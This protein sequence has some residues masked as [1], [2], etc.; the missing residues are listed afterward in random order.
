MGAM[1]DYFDNALPTEQS[2]DLGFSVVSQKVDL[3]VHFAA[4]VISG[5][6]EITIQ[7]EVKDLKTIR[8]NCRQARILSVNVEGSKANHTYTDPY[9]K[10]TL[11]GKR[12]VHQHET[13]RNRIDGATKL[14]P[15]PELAVTIPSR[16]TIRELNSDSSV[17]PFRDALKRQESDAAGRAETPTTSH[18]QESTLRYAPLR[19]VIEFEVRKFRDG[20]H[21]VG[22][23]EQ[24]SRYPHLYTRNTLSPG[25][26]SSVFPC[27]DD[28]STRCMWEISV[29][30]HKTLG[31]AFRKAKSVDQGSLTD[32]DVDMAGTDQQEKKPQDEY[33][34]PLSEEEKSLDLSIVCSGEMTDDVCSPFFITLLCCLT[35]FR[36]LT[37]KIIPGELFRFP[38]SLLSLPV[39]SVLR[40]A[41]SNTWT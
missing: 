15:D 41:H 35:F 21:F 14:S 27:V 16:V 40:S 24:D 10:I 39:I 26:I 33:S 30:C 9:E 20:L 3:T 28:A 12:T 23:T 29:R 37:L 5:T 36:F 17:A 22:F 6:T 38:V 18:A 19:V 34:I 1:P 11:G 4:Q 31:D 13:L 2:L 7:P 8:F 32:G 25:S